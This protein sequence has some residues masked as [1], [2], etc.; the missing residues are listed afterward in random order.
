MNTWNGQDIPANYRQVI[1]DRFIP[2]TK[3]ISDLI[4]QARADPDWNADAKDIYHLDG[5]KNQLYFDCK[6]WIAKGDRICLW[7]TIGNEP[8]YWAHAGYLRDEGSVQTRDVNQADGTKSLRPQVR[9][10]YRV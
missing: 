5:F 4:E 1:E 10:N 8:H 7:D 9:I 2:L 3:H 6:K